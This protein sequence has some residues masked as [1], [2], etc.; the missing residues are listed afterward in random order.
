MQDLGFFQNKVIFSGAT[1]GPCI[2]PGKIG[3]AIEMHYLF[4]APELPVSTPV[5]FRTLK[6]VGQHNLSVPELSCQQLRR[7]RVPFFAYPLVK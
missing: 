6:L 5:S 1:F 4:V 2:G 3:P 7:L